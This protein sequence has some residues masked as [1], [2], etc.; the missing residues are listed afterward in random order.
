MNINK[1]FNNNSQNGKPVG[2]PEALVWAV[3]T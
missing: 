1:T 3:N 2:R